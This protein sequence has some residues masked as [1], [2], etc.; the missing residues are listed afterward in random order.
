V[1]DGVSEQLVAQIV[2]GVD[3]CWE[4]VRADLVQGTCRICGRFALP[5][6]AL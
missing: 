2:A 4:Q 3:D 6:L 1:L 5:V